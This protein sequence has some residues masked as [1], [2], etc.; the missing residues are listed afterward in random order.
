MAKQN[1]FCIEKVEFFVQ[2]NLFIQWLLNKYFLSNLKCLQYR[3]QLV[4]RDIFKTNNTS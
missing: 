4:I 3:K 2:K 1:D